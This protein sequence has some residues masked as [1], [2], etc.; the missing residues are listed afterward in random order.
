MPSQRK[1]IGFLPR[2][3]VQIIIDQISKY[4]KLS[5]SKVTGILVEEALLSRGVLNSSRINKYSLNNNFNC[6]NSSKYDQSLLIS[7]YSFNNETNKDNDNSSLDE[8]SMNDEVKMINDYI[9]FKLFK[10]IMLKHKKDI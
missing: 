1:R 5:Q 9:E 4:N 7:D 2:S 8:Y 3:E 10:N 6:N